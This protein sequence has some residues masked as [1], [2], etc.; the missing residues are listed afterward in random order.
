MIVTFVNSV[1]GFATHSLLL[2]IVICL[3]CLLVGV[4]I[5]FLVCDRLVV[6]VAVIGVRCFTLIVKLAVVCV[7]S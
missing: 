6:F 2:V 4:C 3:W 1:V 7:F 5:G